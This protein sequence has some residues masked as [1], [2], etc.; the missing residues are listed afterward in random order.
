[1]PPAIDGITAIMPVS[2]PPPAPVP[3]DSQDSFAGHLQQASQPTDRSQPVKP[4]DPPRSEKPSSSDK[5]T[6][7]QKPPINDNT[8]AS[9]TPTDGE[10]NVEQPPTA[11]ETSANVATAATIAAIAKELELKNA[12]AAKD[13]ENENASAATVVALTALDGV[14]TVTPTTPQVI[15]APVDPTQ[16]IEKTGVKLD[17]EPTTAAKEPVVLKD[18]AATILD[19][20]ATKEAK[21]KP[22]QDAVAKTQVKAEVAVDAA[23]AVVQEQAAE[24]STVGEPT[25]DAKPVAAETKSTAVEATKPVENAVTAEAIGSVINTVATPSPASN[26]GDDD[27]SK[28]DNTSNQR[29][30]AAIESP[31]GNEPAANAELQGSRAQRPSLDVQ[32]AKQ[33]D[34]DGAAR[35]TEADRARFVQRV[36]RAIHSATENGG[37]IRLRLSPPELGSLRLEIQIVDGQMSAKI[38]AETPAA[39]QALLD[40]LTVLRERLEQQDIKVTRFDVD[41]FDG[42]GGNL[43]QSP[44]RD[45][46][47]ESLLPRH[48]IRGGVE[49]I[50][51]GDATSV[52]GRP[53]FMNDGRL[54]VVI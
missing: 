40:N 3:R 10:A 11:D 50:A 30:I 52:V 48:A 2:E 41:L 4:S 6:S 21:A 45:P 38:E 27:P 12:K 18:A 32:V 25:T 19:T 1:M 24:E 42:A 15:A 7:T 23:K 39:R 33:K 49:K 43:S 14:P 8:R 20:A 5:P 47:Q 44:Q 53:T 9:A 54:N 36:S 34:Q 37:P 31:R 29:D 51:E 17:D 46:G 28:K 13:E 16:A 22:V 26:R 35:M